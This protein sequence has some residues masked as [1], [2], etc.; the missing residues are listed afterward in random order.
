MKNFTILAIAASLTVGASAQSRNGSIIDGELILQ[1]FEGENVELMVVPLNTKAADR[2]QDLHKCDGGI[3]EYKGSKMG[4][5]FSAY[6]HRLATD[7]DA[8]GPWSSDIATIFVKVTLPEGQTLADFTGFKIDYANYD[9]EKST[10]TGS[11]VLYVMKEDPD[12]NFR[13]IAQDPETR[14]KIE[15]IDSGNL[16]TKEFTMADINTMQMF[17]QKKFH[18]DEWSGS[19]W[20]GYCTEKKNN[21]FYIDNIRLT[22]AKESALG[23]VSSENALSVSGTIGGIRLAGNGV[24]SVYTLTGMEV[25]NLSVADEARVSLTPGMY[26]VR[27]NGSSTKVIVR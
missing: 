19:F 8:Q 20:I 25:A 17:S 2:E 5:A 24:A 15:G 6:F 22:G 11:H 14:G 3:K 16:F 4:Y 12:D 18:A 13:V 23:N 7:P 9:P 26:V 1:D 21:G 27:V 10:V